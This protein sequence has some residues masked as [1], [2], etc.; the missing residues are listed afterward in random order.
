MSSYYTAPKNRQQKFRHVKD[1]KHVSVI[2]DE[3]LNL[4][5]HIKISK[6]KLARGIGISC[7]A[8]KLLRSS[9]LLTLYNSFFYFHIYVIV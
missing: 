8:R 2:I 6:C 3:H 7:K 9:T 5:S 1:T 4:A